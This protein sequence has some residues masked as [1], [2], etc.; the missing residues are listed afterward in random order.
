[1]LEIAGEGASSET[2]TYEKRVVLM[3]EL[4][5]VCVWVECGGVVVVMSEMMLLREWYLV[6]ACVACG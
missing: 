1:M 6:C 4:E 3:D 5:I 2:E